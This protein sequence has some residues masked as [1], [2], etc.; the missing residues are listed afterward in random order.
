[1]NMNFNNVTIKILLSLTIICLL[2]NLF[3][4]PNQIEGKEIELEVKH[5]NLVRK[6]KF[7][8]KK[9][10]NYAL[11]TLGVD[12]IYDFEILLRDQNSIVDKYEIEIDIYDK[13]S[14]NPIPHDQ[15]LKNIKIH[16]LINYLKSHLDKIST[17]FWHYNFTYSLRYSTRKS[18]YNLIEIPE[19]NEK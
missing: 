19:E 14:E 2:Y 4:L 18:F 3:W 10:N 12:P 6:V 17:E 13:E 9:L 16:F 5:R 15:L 8:T 11:D 1:M 7:L